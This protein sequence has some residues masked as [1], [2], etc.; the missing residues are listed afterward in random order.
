M[1]YIEFKEKL[2]RKKHKESKRYNDAENKMR[3]R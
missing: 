3:I 1:E 2:Y